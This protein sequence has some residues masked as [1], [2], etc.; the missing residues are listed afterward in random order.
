MGKNSTTKK[1]RAANAAPQRNLAKERLRAN[2]RTTSASNQQPKKRRAARPAP[3]DSRSVVIGI[4]RQQECLKKLNAP[5]ERTPASRVTRLLRLLRNMGGNAT[6]TQAKRMLLAIEGGGV[7]T[8]EART[9]LDVISP[10]ARVSELRHAGHE[11]E[12]IWRRQITGAGSVHRVG[13]YIS[14]RRG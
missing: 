5:M 2:S 12:T 8:H 14:A 9:Y 11:I 10:S 3:K 1:G 6:E 7:T 4:Y 13:K